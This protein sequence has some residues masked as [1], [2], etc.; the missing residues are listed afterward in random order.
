LKTSSPVV[1][2]VRCTLTAVAALA[3]LLASAASLAIKDASSHAWEI[4]VTVVASDSTFGGTTQNP[5]LGVADSDDS[6]L[7]DISIALSL[8]ESVNATSCIIASRSVHQTRNLAVV[9]PDH[10]IALPGTPPPTDRS[11]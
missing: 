4:D 3:P 1:S 10:L 7:A 9:A 6:D 5:V 11:V 2:I 8:A